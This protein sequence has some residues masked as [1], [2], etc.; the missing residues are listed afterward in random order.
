MDQK[1]FTR[2]IITTDPSWGSCQGARWVSERRLLPVDYHN[3][4]IQKSD[5]H[6]TPAN[7]SRNRLSRL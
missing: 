7:L 3:V 4:P 1:G 2:V 6:L 5:I